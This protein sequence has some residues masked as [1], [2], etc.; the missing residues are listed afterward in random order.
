MD[1]SP[2]G[3]YRYPGCRRGPGASRPRARRGSALRGEEVAMIDVETAGSCTRGDRRQR[4][5]EESRRDARLLE[6]MAADLIGLALR[7]APD[8]RLLAEV[9]RRGLLFDGPPSAGGDGLTVVRLFPPPS[10]ADPHASVD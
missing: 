1:R 10:S 8:H 5:P 6:A 4:S 9:R 7:S 3:R 2:D